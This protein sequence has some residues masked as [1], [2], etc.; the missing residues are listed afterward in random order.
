VTVIV[1]ARGEIVS[2]PLGG[3]AASSPESLV[4]IGMT[5]KPLS[6][7][8]PTWKGDAPSPRLLTLESGVGSVTSLRSPLPLLPQAAATTNIKTI[9]ARATAR[10]TMRIVFH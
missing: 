10:R 2:G 8:L 1:C 4:V 9:E 5:A 3:A 6:L 7:P